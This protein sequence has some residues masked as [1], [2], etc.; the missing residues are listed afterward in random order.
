MDK[1]TEEMITF[2]RDNSSGRTR[3]ELT[4]L[5]NEHFNTRKSVNAIEWAC[6]SNKIKGNPNFIKGIC[7]HKNIKYK[8]GDECFLAGEWRIITSTEEKVPILKRC[9]YKKRIIWQQAHGNIPEKHV[10]IYLD[11]D[12]RN[13]T[14]ENLACVPLLWM[15]IIN[16]N[17]W[18][19]DSRSHTITALKWCELHYAL[20]VSDGNRYVKP[21]GKRYR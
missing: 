9:E 20:S 3:K 1:Y 13:C 7:P 12:K 19:T 2:L 5:F 10:L 15:R 4:E 14:L 8:I 17:G 11:G 6:K 18:L 21:S 16:Q